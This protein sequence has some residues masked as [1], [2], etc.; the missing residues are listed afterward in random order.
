MTDTR[1]IPF[2]PDTA[3][4][5]LALEIAEAFGDTTRL[6]LYRRVCATHDRSVVH[7]AFR[8]AMEIPAHQVRKSRPAIFFAILCAYDH[9]HDPRC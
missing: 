9:R 7:K 1:P 3:A 5:A 2:V 6:F 8:E 4:D